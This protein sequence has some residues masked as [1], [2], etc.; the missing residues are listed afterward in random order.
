[1][2]NNMN[3]I[4]YSPKL[5]AHSDMYSFIIH[6]SIN[7]VI[8]VYGV[9]ANEYQVSNKK[10]TLIKQQTIQILPN[11]TLSN[12]LKLPQYPPVSPPSSPPT[13]SNPPI[14]PFTT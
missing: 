6:I 5:S 4:C 1:M 12:F 2:N 11:T 13:K 8:F 10:W 9:L 3:L 7:N 14:A